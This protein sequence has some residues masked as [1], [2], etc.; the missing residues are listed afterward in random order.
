MQKLYSKPIKEAIIK[1]LKKKIE[2]NHLDNMNMAIITSGTDDASKVYIK[3]KKKL[4]NKLGIEVMII[5]LNKGYEF[6]GMKLDNNSSTQEMLLLIDYLVANK[7]PMMIQMPLQN[8]MDDEKLLNAIP[9]YL[10]ID[11]LTKYSLGEILSKGINYE[12]NIACTPHGIIDLLDA[13][14]I[15]LEGKNILIIG[16]SEIVGKPLI[17]LLLSKNATVEIAHSKTRPMELAKKMRKADIIISQVGKD[18]FFGIR[19][20]KDDAIIIDV[21]MN[22]NKDG[23]L[24]GDF[25]PLGV[26]DTNIQYTP[27]PGGVG[28]MTVTELIRNVVNTNYLFN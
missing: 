26:E 25:N 18:N 2:N 10:D 28:P 22:R 5:D 27:V 3:Q 19:D 4:A 1:D 7:V 17:G 9:A 11:G 6:N 15:N 20:V 12:G 8:D 24:C 14:N 13:Y 23:K 21:S 16:R